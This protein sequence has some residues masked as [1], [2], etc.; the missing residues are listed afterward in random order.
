M[1]IHSKVLLYC[2]LFKTDY[3]HGLWNSYLEILCVKHFP[4]ESGRLTTIGILSN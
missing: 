3:G 2:L 4:A 1:D